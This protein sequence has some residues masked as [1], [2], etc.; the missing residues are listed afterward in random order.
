MER[1]LDEFAV[2]VLSTGLPRL[3]SGL[4]TGVLV[5]IALWRGA[6]FGAVL[7]VRLW[8]N[9][10]VDSECALVE[11]EVDGAW[12]AVLGSGGGGWIDDPLVRN[13]TGW[14]GDPVLWIGSNGIGLQPDDEDYEPAFVPAEGKQ[15]GLVSRPVIV[16][17]P[18][19]LDDDQAR[20]YLDEARK[21]DRRRWEARWDRLDL[22]A[23][24][25]VASTQVQAIEVEQGDRRWRVPIDSPCGAFLVGLEQRGPATVRALGH[26]GR[27]L[28]DADG[29]TEHTAASL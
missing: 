15:L 17:V 28:A 6:R 16:R 21:A 9:G 2:T 27:P 22:R 24:R 23:L 20:A 25:G 7:F 12:G 29:R 13:E 4:E 14:D 10:N 5:P 11:R 3:P 19:G 1:D 18:E 26:D 8:T